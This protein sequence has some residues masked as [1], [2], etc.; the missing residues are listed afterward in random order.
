M[1]RKNN[2]DEDAFGQEDSLIDDEPVRRKRRKR[3]SA[4]EYDEY[5][6]DD[7]PD[8]SVAHRRKKA[9]IDLNDID[10]RSVLMVVAVILVI[11]GVVLLITKTNVVSTAS[12]ALSIFLTA[13]TRWLTYT[14]IAWGVFM[15][16]C[17]GIIFRGVRNIAPAAAGCFLVMGAVVFAGFFVP[18]I[19]TLLIIVLL[20]LIAFRIAFYR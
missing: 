1:R 6:I 8:R 12:N 15:F 20:I 7:M 3:R 19:N 11:A 10:L 2:L 14:A 17:S 13:L 4:Y 5:P 16:S 9:R 18:A